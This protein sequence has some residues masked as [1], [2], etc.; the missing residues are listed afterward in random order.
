[1]TVS[2]ACEADDM[3]RDYSAVS[4]KLKAM[5]GTRLT[6]EAFEALMQKK[7]VPEICSELKKTEAYGKAFAGAD[8]TLLHR[9]ETERLLDNCFYG[10]YRRLYSFVDAKKRNV[11]KLWFMR[12]E[13][14]VLSEVLR[15]ISNGE[16]ANGIKV[17]DFFVDHTRIDTEA[18][19]NAKSLSE[20]AEACKNTDY[21]DI[22]TRA[23]DAGSEFFSLAMTLD[24]NYFVQMK[25]IGDKHLSGE[26]RKIFADMYN[27]MAQMLNVMWIYRGKKYFNFDAEMIY[28]YLLPTSGRSGEEIIEAMVR[29]KD[30]RA[31][32]EIAA[33][34]P[35]GV[36]FSGLDEGIFPEEMYRYEL[37]RI[38]ARILR[39]KPDTM[40]A[41]FAYLNLKDAELE[42]ITM[43]IE[44]VRYSHNPDATRKHIMIYRGE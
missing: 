43:I 37:S 8:E 20:A 28:T 39:D 22:L 41:V 17:S 36:L 13:T 4:A 44:A 27:D 18:L 25:K 5:Y 12:R 3:S 2:S 10:E 33:K 31:V 7:S 30:S 26:E 6:K 15:R 35:F 24:C 23:E 40:A 1:M 29:A 14:D 19:F 21:Y 9:G 38:S 34:T 16:S 42:T 11:L 32:V